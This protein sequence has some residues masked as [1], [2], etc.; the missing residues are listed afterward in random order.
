MRSPALRTPHDAIFK[1]G[2]ETPEHAA[3]LFRQVLPTTIVDTLDWSTIAREPGS[4][5]D[6]SLAPSHSDLLF[7]VQRAELPDKRVLLYLLLEHQSRSDAHMPLR[8]LAYEVRIWQRYLKEHPG[9]LSTIPPLPPIIPIVISHDPD[10][11]TAPTSFHAL[12]DPPLESIPELPRYVPSFELR[13]ED[14]IEIDDERLRSWQ[15]ATFAMLAIWMLRDARDPERLR[16]SFPEWA[17]LL[18]QLLRTPNGRNEVEQVLRYIA[19]VAGELRFQEF[20]ETIRQQLPEAEEVAMTIAEELRAE[21]RAEGESKGVIKGRAEGVLEGRAEG[22]AHALTK[23][24]TL[25]FGPPS[26]A[27]AARIEAATEQQLDSFIERVL[28]AP[29]PDAV[30][31]DD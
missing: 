29:T 21:G 2:F 9:P 20:R 7:S 18:R 25:R 1:A 17:D 4:F 13:I 24:M 3:G 26:T 14:L 28:T 31:G 11:W 30:F 6:P 27:Q 23:L 12:F 16:R 15:L 5:I 10:G 22:R 19:L 8:I